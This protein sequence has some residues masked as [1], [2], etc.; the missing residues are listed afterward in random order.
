M[1]ALWRELEWN[2]WDEACALDFQN[3]SGNLSSD[4]A[5][6]RQAVD[7]NDNIYNMEDSGHPAWDVCCTGLVIDMHG[8]V[9]GDVY[10]DRLCLL[11]R[12]DVENI[13]Q[14]N[15]EYV[16]VRGLSHRHTVSWNPGVAESRP[17]AVCY[18]CLCLISFFRTVMSLSYDWDE[19]FG[20]I[21]HDGGYACFSVGVLEYLPR[22]LYS[23][24]VMNRMTQYL[25]QMKVLGWS[26]VHR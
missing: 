13:M 19:V 10:I 11:G 25:T 12:Y 15:E 1:R 9:D 18:D 4:S 14:K 20:W 22:C 5:V 8:Y 6:V 17:L 3:A 7:I 26:L 2:T 21:G 23:P 16:D 24:L